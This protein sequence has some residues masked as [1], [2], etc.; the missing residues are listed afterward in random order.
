MQFFTVPREMP[1][2]PEHLMALVCPLF[3]HS[4]RIDPIRSGIVHHQTGK[5]THYIGP[6]IRWLTVRWRPR[7]R[8]TNQHFFS[9]RIK[10]TPTDRLVGRVRP[11]PPIDRTTCI[12]LPGISPAAH[13]GPEIKK[14]HDQIQNIIIV[15][16][17]QP[18]SNTNS[19]IHTIFIKYQID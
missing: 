18:K 12:G 19:N 5:P 7:R 4:N 17:N 9:H 11:R 16:E 10:L 3:L 1:T 8:P 14:N 6:L 2:P 15:N 13:Y